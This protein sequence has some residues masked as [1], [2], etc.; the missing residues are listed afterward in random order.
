MSNWYPF[1]Y[2]MFSVSALLIIVAID[3]LNDKYEAKAK[4]AQRKLRF[5]LHIAINQGRG[6]SW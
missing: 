2:A 6:V 5:K 4:K 1:I 3:V